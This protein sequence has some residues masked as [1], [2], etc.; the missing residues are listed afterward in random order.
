MAFED[1]LNTGTRSRKE[2]RIEKQMIETENKL[3]K[4]E[5][6]QAQAKRYVEEF[7]KLCQAYAH[8]GKHKCCLYAGVRYGERDY[9]NAVYFSKNKYASGLRMD[10]NHSKKDLKL[11]KGYL[12]TALRNAGFLKAKVSLHK[13]RDVTFLL[14][15]A[16]W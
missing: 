13:S 10:N 3:R 8:A 4:I 2:L 7:S 5:Y 16:R 11:M 1:D 15:K 9:F 12:E 14:M 6:D